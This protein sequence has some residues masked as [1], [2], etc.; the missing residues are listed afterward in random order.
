MRKEPLSDDDIFLIHE[1][2]SP[3][4]CARFMARS[5]ELGYLEAP[6]TTAEGP[7]MNKNVRDNHRLMVDDP[8]LA[9]ELFERARPFLP[10]RVNR[11]QPSG[12]NERWRYYRYDPDERFA[13]HYDGH[14]ARSADEKSQLTFMIY[15]N[16]GFV[17]G[18][19]NFYRPGVPEPFVTVAPVAGL[20]LVFVHWKLHEGAPVERGRKYV[21]RTDVLCRRVASE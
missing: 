10:A 1:F 20:A 17:G 2:L 13:P 3:T 6:I 4:E 9:E 12:F 16:G 14:F 19:T 8:A 11:W 18:A 5:E 15:L 21:L 7:V